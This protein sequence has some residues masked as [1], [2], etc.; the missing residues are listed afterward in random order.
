MYQ[1]HF[2]LS[3]A[4]NYQWLNCMFYSH[5]TL[6]QL[7]FKVKKEI[8]V[9]PT[10]C[11]QNSM[12]SETICTKCPYCQKEMTE[13]HIHYLPYKSRKLYTKSSFHHI[14]PCTSHVNVFDMRIDPFFWINK[15]TAEVICPKDWEK[16]LE[17]YPS[18]KSP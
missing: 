10:S 13:W 17:M 7:S 14:F 18:S 2:Y 15:Y 1:L 12:Q 8:P 9:L 3:S 4:F 5:G 16:H 6:R 11:K